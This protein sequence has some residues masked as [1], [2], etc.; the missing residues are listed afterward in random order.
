MHCTHDITPTISDIASTVSVSSQPLYWWSLTNC[1]YDIT[2]TLCMTSYALYVTSHP[3]F[4]ISHRCSHHITSTGFMTSHTLY[5]TSHTWQHKRY[6]GHLTHYIWHTS[7]VSVSSN[8]VYQWYH[9]H[10]LD[11][12]IHTICMASY[13]VCMALHEPFMTS[14]PY[15]Y[16]I[17]PSMFMT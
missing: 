15:M 7:T 2:P 5:M 12:I 3:L 8:P 13:S 10:S 14:H 1:M 17:T 4:M 6:I 16:D 11:D 9:S